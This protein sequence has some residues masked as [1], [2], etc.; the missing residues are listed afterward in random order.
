[1]AASNQP[2]RVTKTVTTSN[3]KYY[4]GSTDPRRSN[5]LTQR[6]ERYYF[7]TLEA[8]QAFQSRNG[9][10]VQALTASGKSYQSV[11]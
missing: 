7:P 1:M 8:A 2:Y 9:G 11:R 10:V 4:A 6:H 5:P 3:R